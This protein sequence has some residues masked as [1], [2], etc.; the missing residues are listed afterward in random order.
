MPSYNEVSEICKVCGLEYHGLKHPNP[1][2]HG[3]KEC[4]RCK[5]QKMKRFCF[6]GIELIYDSKLDAW[7]CENCGYV[8][9]YEIKEDD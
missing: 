2:Y 1:I 5:Q 3:H 8:D 6:C 4:P 7:A 9:D